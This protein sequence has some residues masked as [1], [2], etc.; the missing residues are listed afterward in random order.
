MAIG[1]DVLRG[2]LEVVILQLILEKDR[3]AYDIS[4][5]IQTRTN[6]SF[7]VKEAT[8]YALVQRL[9]RKELI[10]SYVGTKSHGSKRRYYTLTALGRAYYHERLREW[11]ELKDVMS[12]LLEDTHEGN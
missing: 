4:K 9:E 12:Q 1:S 11:N 5:E 3:Y 7:S 2:H 8:L 6:A 10:R